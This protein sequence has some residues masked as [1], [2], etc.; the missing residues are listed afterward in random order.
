MK[1]RAKGNGC[2]QIGVIV[3]EMMY[4]IGFWHKQSGPDRDDYIWIYWQNI[5]RGKLTMLVTLTPSNNEIAKK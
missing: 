1:F 2:V 5:M 3:H 4:A